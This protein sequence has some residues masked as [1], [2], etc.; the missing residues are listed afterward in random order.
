MV[1]IYSQQR[2][3]V[4][5]DGESVSAPVES[6]EATAAR[7][8]C[9]VMVTY[10]AGAE[11]LENIRIVLPQ[12]QAL[13]VVD[14]GS[15]AGEIAS[16]RESSQASGFQ[17]IENHEN[18][19]VAEALNQGIAWARSRGY[20]WVI[21]FDQDSTITN[22]FVLQMFATWESHP[23]R[24]RVGSIHPRYQDRVTGIEAPI[25]RAKDDGGPII[26]LT[27]GALIPTWI[28][29]RIGYFASDFFIDCVDIEFCFRLR[30]SGYYVAGSK[31]A[32]LLHSPGYPERVSVMG[33][34]ISPTHHSAVRRYYISRNRIVVY[35]KYFHVFPALVLQYA[36]AS[37][38]ETAKCFLAERDRARK[39]RNFLLGTWDGLVGRM[40]KR[41]NL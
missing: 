40:G 28:F 5:M 29:D 20:P 30:A 33:F 27:S 11:T 37:L 7:S 3:L 21:L 32:I 35:R 10:H 17:L 15:A 14:N 34:V 1:N 25:Q 22:E 26:S 19:G 9:A 41:E 23:Q 2:T 8:V 6:V 12:V 36:Y 24:E 38:R 39:L 18:R 16:L 13:V 31:E 4:H